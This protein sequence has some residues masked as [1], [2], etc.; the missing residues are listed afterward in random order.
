[1]LSSTSYANQIQYQTGG[2]IGS[3]NISYGLS[4]GS[5]EIK[6]GTGYVEESTSSPE[7]NLFN[8]N[9]NYN[10]F[11]PVH[12]NTIN[13]NF[14][15]CKLGLGLVHNTSNK[16]FTKLPSKYPDDYYYPTSTRMIFNYDLS[17]KFQNKI[18][19]YTT[20]VAIDVGLS[21]YLRNADFFIDNYEFFG[22]SGVFNY[23]IGVR[24]DF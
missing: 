21:T 15:W 7:F 5:H 4:W 9:Y 18:E 22:L 10:C 2:L 19:I 8:I 20:F 23:G 3:Y 1:M 11:S 12:I 13:A 6:L 14:N 16:L 17:L 24:Y